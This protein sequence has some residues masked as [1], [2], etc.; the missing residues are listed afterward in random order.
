MTGTVAYSISAFFSPSPPRGI[1]RSTTPVCV[2]TSRSSSRPPPAT[3]ATTSAGTPTDATASRASS[4]STAFECAAIDEPRSTIAFPDFSASAVQSIVTFGRDSYTTAITPSGTRTFRT[5]S[6]FGSRNPSSTSPTGSR[7]AA[8]SRTPRAI[9]AT[10]SGVSRSRSRRAEPI[11]PSSPASRSRAFAS[12]TSSTRAS[13]WAAIASRAASRVPESSLARTREA[14]FAE[15]QISATVLVRTAIHCKGTDADPRHRLP[16]ANCSL[17]HEVIP[18]HRFL[19]R[20]RQQLPHLGALQAD[21]A[22]QLGGR[23]VDD[24]LADRAAVGGHLDRVARLEVA[25][26]ADDADGQKRR[27]TLPQRGRRALV[28]HQPALARLRVLQPQLAARHASLLRHGARARVAARERDGHGLAPG[29]AR[30]PGGD[31]GRRRH[32]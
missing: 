1:R 30:T 8:I 18:V 29:P 17:E 21:H 10:R 28:D 14:S 19:R 25:L 5:S 32:L 11:C 31:A 12:R 23:V 27:P 15:A 26:D 9:P 4:A 7:S 6:P 13:S 2:A 16:T 20:P 24:P 22:P 3:S